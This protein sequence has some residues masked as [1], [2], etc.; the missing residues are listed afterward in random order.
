MIMCIGPVYVGNM[1]GDPRPNI[2][3]NAFGIRP[4]HA[5]FQHKDDGYIYLKGTEEESLDYIMINGERM[6]ENPETGITEQ[7]LY[8]LDRI[9]FGKNTI[10][11]FKYPLMKRKYMEI[12]ESIREKNP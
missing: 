1:R 9:L 12:K 6:Q 2:I 4:N 7:R 10:F 5:L 11:V 3:L 8:H